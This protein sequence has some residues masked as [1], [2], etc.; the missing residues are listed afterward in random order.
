MPSLGLFLELI[1]GL[2]LGLDFGL[3]SLD[4]GAE[5]SFRDCEKKLIFAGHLVYQEIINRILRERE[6]VVVH[7]LFSVE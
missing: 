1:A 4:V 5:G 7:Q 2:P 6:A 3:D